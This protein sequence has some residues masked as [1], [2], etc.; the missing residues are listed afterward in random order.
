MWLQGVEGARGMCAKANRRPAL[1]GKM[2]EPEVL[3]FKIF[4]EQGIVARV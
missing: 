4:R 1:A 2:R 3:L